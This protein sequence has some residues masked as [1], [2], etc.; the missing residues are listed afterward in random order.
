MILPIYIYGSRVLYQQAKDISE[1]DFQSNNVSIK[2]LI[3]DMLDTMINANGIGL[4]ANQVGVLKSIIV[5]NQAMIDDK[6]EERANNCPSVLIN[7][8][9]TEKGED[10]IFTSEEC[11]SFPHL[12]AGVDRARYIVVEYR[13]ELFRPQ[14][15]TAFDIGAVV[16]QHEIDHLRGITLNIRVRGMY[17]KR[18][19]TMIKKITRSKTKIDVGYPSIIEK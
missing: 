11:L 5:L 15:L 17:K 3:A 19:N 16:L 7:P 8:H 2:K 4:A 14:T 12:T 9:I 13:D 18:L 10:V 6:Q 1:D